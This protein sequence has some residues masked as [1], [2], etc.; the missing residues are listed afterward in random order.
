[1]I[2]RYTGEEKTIDLVC[3]DDRLST[4]FAAIRANFTAEWGIFETWEIE[5]MMPIEYPIEYQDAA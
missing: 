3:N 1:M 5:P 2:H 4:I